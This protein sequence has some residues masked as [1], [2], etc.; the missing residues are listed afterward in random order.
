MT[1]K[2][3]FNARHRRKIGVS[4]PPT[5]CQRSLQSSSAVTMRAYT[6]LSLIAGIASAQYVPPPDPVLLTA[7]KSGVLPVLPPAFTGVETLEGAIM[8]KAPV[9]ASYLPANGPAQVQSNLPSATYTAQLPPV[10]FNELTGTVIAGTVTGSSTQGGTGVTWT[11]SLTNLPDVSQYGPFVYHVHDMP[12][13][14]D[15]NC[16]SAMGHFDYTNSGEYYTCDTSNPQ[17]CQV[18]D[19]AGKHGKIMSGPTFS[20]QFVDNYLSTDPSSPY[21]F[22][23]KSLVIHTS[24]TTRLTCANFMMSAGSGSSATASGPV[25]T[26]TANTAATRSMGG[27]LFAGAAALFAWML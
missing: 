3:V 25:A 2:E 7:T 6:L 24:N 17:N 5:L 9:N 22:G 23:Q 8:Q 21:F 16:T 4:I 27:G 13:P 18:G 26:Y 14:A 1:T 12:V 15:G 20:T 11:V 19:L 10:A